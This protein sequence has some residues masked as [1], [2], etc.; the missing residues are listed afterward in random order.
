MMVVRDLCFTGCEGRSSNGGLPGQ[1][2][3]EED[4]AP[5]QQA[6]RLHL[7]ER[8]DLEEAMSGHRT[9]KYACRHVFIMH[10]DPSGCSEN[11]LPWLQNGAGFQGRMLF[12]WPL[13]M[14]DSPQ[15]NRFSEV[16][17][18]YNFPLLRITRG[19]NHRG[20]LLVVA[21]KMFS[22]SCNQPSDTGCP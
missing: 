19:V 22:L 17:F 1:D 15:I 6:R 5:E 8:S 16:I 13:A 18:L 10:Y 4:Q 3:S 9:C 20:R 2:G 7:A 11:P 14:R 12:A 21:P